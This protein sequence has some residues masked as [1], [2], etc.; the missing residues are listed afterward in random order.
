MDNALAFLKPLSSLKSQILPVIYP[1]VFSLHLYPE[2]IDSAVEEAL[3]T[4][5]MKAKQFSE[6]QE[7]VKGKVI[8]RMLQ[9]LV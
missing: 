8:K 9:M 2:V 7:E 1:A 3:R 6:T 4:C 5:R